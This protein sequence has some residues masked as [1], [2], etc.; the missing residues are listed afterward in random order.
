MK[1]WEYSGKDVIIVDIDGRTFTGNVD[2]YTSELDDPNGI[3]SI[4][5]APDN[6]SDI[7]INFEE[8]EIARIECLSVPSRELAIAV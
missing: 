5:L 8:S 1:L 4:S 2:H 6:R 7:L 3:A